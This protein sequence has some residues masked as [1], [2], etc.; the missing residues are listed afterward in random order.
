MREGLEFIE[1][2]HHAVLGNALDRVIDG[3]ISRLIVTMP[4]GYTKTAMAVVNFIAR[5]FSINP[6]A[7]FI[8]ATFSDD[9]ARDNS[10]QIKTLIELPE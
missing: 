1:G 8:H 6:A 10:D 7:R 9:L 4:P 3:E 2:P 5:G